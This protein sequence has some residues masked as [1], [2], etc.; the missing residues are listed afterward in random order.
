MI[1]WKSQPDRG[2]CVNDKRCS[3]WNNNQ[4]C[5]S[6][7][8]GKTKPENRGKCLNVVVEKVKTPAKNTSTK[9]AAKK[10]TKK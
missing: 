3:C 7:C 4:K 2:V 6:H 1:D 5:S 10:T 8:H 9:K